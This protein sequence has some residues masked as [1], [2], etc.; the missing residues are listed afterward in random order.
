MSGTIPPGEGVPA[1]QQAAESR[2]LGEEETLTPGY[3]GQTPPGQPAT[4]V[5]IAGWT[6]AEIDVRDPSA[7]LL[8]PLAIALFSLDVAPRREDRAEP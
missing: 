1:P 7:A 6:L 4:L 8:E 2:Q 3:A 5:Q